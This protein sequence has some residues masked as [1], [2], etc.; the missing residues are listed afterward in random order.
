MGIRGGFAHCSD[1]FNSGRQVPR[2][3]ESLA[4]ECPSSQLGV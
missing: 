1:R 2:Q 3:P 4:V